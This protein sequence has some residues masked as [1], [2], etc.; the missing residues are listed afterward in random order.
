M[1]YIYIYMHI[2]CLSIASG[3][4]PSGTSPKREPISRRVI[5][6]INKNC[7]SDSET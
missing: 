3:A 2:V 7:D 6:P 5:A 4:F 1:I